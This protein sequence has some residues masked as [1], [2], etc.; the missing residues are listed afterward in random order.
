MSDS[1][2]CNQC[3]TILDEGSSIQ[4][5]NREPC[6]VCGS[7]TRQISVSIQ[8]SPAV[9]MAVSGSVT[10]TVFN[11]SSLLLQAVV[12]PGAKTHEGLL[13]EAVT[14]PWFDIIELLEKD[15][16]LAYQINAIKWE[17]IVAGAYQKAGFDEVT[18]TPRSG[19]YGRDI[20]AV[21]RGLGTVRIIDQVKAYNPNH[22]V[23]ADDVRALLGVLEGDKAS[24]G[25]LSTT[26]DFAP[27]LR[28]DILI[29]QFIP[30]RI[31][32]INGKMLLARLI[33]IA[34]RRS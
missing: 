27:K 8:L 19:D 25:F 28:D 1:V 24:K 31:E 18:L 15:P 17:E 4:P 29:K 9:L 22:L 10:V 3:G 30:D 14:L 33:E 2:A 32:L 11:A 21:K 26:S 23:T 13:I 7:L 20:I 34:K 6:P 12:V 5:E 16:F